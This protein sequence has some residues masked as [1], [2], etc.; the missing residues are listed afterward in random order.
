VECSRE[1][2]KAIDAAYRVAHKKEK[3][4]YDVAYRAAHKE[5]IKAYNLAHR[6][7]HKEQHK[8]YDSERK[9]ESSVRSHHRM[10][11]G[12]NKT[13]PRKNNEGMPFCDAW[14]PKKGGSYRAGGDWIIANLGRKPEGC[15]LHIVEHEKGFVPGNLVWTDPVKQNAEQMFKIIAR[16]RREVKILQEQND[17]LK[18]RVSVFEHNAR[19]AA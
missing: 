17:N 8:V 18:A 5:E 15:T 1:H 14:N 9:E 12:T 11:F 7:A 3:N 10:I 19:V 2:E 6:A 13:P 4:S 16:L